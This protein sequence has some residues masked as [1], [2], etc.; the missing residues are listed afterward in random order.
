LT[1][2]GSGEARSTLLEERGD[3]LLEVGTRHERSSLRTAELDAGRQTKP[4][5]LS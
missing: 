5:C 4:F 3:A 1:E 2:H